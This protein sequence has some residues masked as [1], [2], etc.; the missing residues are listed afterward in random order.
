M[1]DPEKDYKTP[2]HIASGLYFVRNIFYTHLYMM[3]NVL[4]HLLNKES[5]IETR[6]TNT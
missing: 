6:P 3:F 5:D 2:K 4:Y 1:T